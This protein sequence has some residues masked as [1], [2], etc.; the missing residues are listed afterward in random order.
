MGDVVCKSEPMPPL[1]QGSIYQDSPMSSSIDELDDFSKFSLYQLLNAADD[2]S[3]PSNTELSRFMNVSSLNGFDGDK[4]FYN[5]YPDSETCFST[6]SETLF[7]ESG[8]N[9]TTFFETRLEEREIVDSAF[10]DDDIL[11]YNKS[12][13]FE[14]YLDL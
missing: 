12:F 10:K 1:L 2:N 7:S 3:N 9:G 14:E 13:E 5:A 11:A 4:D 8:S 6:P